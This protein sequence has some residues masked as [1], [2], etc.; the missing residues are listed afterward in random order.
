MRIRTPDDYAIAVQA[1]EQRAIAW[2]REAWVNCRDMIP[3]VR[4]FIDVGANVGG[5]ALSVHE[6][7]PHCWGALY[8]PVPALAIACAK[9][10]SGNPNMMVYR[11]AVGATEGDCKM[12]LN[13]NA[14][15]G[16][17]SILGDAKE[18]DLDRLIGCYEELQ[19]VPHV[20]KMAR[21]DDMPIPVA[22]DL[23]KIDVEGAE[24]GVLEG[25]MQVIADNRPIIVLE[26]SYGSKRHPFWA[27]EVAAVNA[28][29]A[30]GYDMFG[31]PKTP[32]PLGMSD[33]AF[34]EPGDVVLL[35]RAIG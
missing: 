21:L 17:N 7:F 31:M 12:W 19:G 14:V 33:P 2:G 8:E 35:P 11:N 5:F 29:L 32:I 10:F 34:A 15:G 1:S 30:L 9:R 22:L 23:I 28:V 16:N 20:A 24:F 3:F 18:E 6:A 4:G 25:A 26:I 13:L 27:R